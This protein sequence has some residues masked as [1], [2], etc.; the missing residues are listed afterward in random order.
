M[1]KNFKTIRLI[2]KISI[3]AVL[4]FLLSYI[5]FPLPFAPSFYK[6]D[7]TSVPLLIGGFA[8]GPFAAVMIEIIR[9]IIK[10]I[11][12]PTDSFF[13]GEL[14]ALL[15]NL[16]FVI[17]ASFLYR[18]N[19]TNKRA[20]LSLIIGVLSFT[21]VG[22]LSN[23]YLIIPAYVKVMGFPLDA[24]INLGKA[25]NNNV[26]SVFTLVLYCTT[27]FNLFKSIISAVVVKLVY[28]YLSYHLKNTNKL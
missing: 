2:S 6:M 14:S 16:A 8:F 4:S 19:K 7:F 25:V 26:N 24:I 15:V 28:K 21:L 1:S 18:N 17:P 3:L 9:S 27:P 20:I 10:L 22:A 11:F 5:S 13:I 12:I 23:Y